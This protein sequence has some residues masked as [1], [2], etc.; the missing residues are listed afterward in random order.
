MYTAAWLICYMLGTCDV[1][2]K[3]EEVIFQKEQ[4]CLE[5]ADRQ[6]KILISMLEKEGI[7]AQIQYKCFKR[8]TI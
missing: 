5:Y 2:T 3:N 7:P 8:E 4:Q 6:A 1:I